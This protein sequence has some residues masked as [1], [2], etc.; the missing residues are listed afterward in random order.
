MSNS[1]LHVPYILSPDIKNERINEYQRKFYT[2]SKSFAATYTC[3]CCL[4]LLLRGTGQKPPAK[5]PIYIYNLYYSLLGDFLSGGFCPGAYIRGTFVLDPLLSTITK[6]NRVNNSRIYLENQF[7]HIW[8]ISCM[9]KLK[10]HL[11]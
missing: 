3:I 2:N 5:I 11:A 8:W 4:S 6:L 10:R 7:V 9:Y 1:I